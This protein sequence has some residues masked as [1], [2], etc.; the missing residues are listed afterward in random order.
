MMDGSYCNTVASPPL[1]CPTE[2]Q[3]V[4]IARQHSEG[5]DADTVFRE[6]VNAGYE[7]AE[8]R[9]SVQRALDKKVLTLGSRMKLVAA[10]EM[11]AA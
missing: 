2:Q 4:A 6:L 8:I 10:R 5:V 1:R 3:L 7:P 11:V 9:R